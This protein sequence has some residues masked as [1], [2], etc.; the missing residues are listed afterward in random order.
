MTKMKKLLMLA[1]AGVVPASFQ[2]E[3]NAEIRA[4]TTAV[5]VPAPVN[6]LAQT[7]GTPARLRRSNER[8]PGN[9]M[10]TLAFFADGKS[11]LYFVMNTE[12]NN[13]KPEHRV[14]LAMVPFVLEQD[15]T[16]AVVAK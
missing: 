2:G 5:V 10:P 7:S 12:L 6:D 14:Q 3:A 13:Q 8:Q 1:A 15:A 4:A 16:G 9:E 11:G